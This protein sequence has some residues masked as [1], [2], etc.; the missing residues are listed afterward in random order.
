MKS[1]KSILCFCA[2]AVLLATTARASWFEFCEIEGEIDSVSVEKDGSYALIVN[3]KSA[4]RTSAEKDAIQSHTDCHEHI[5]KTVDA[6]FSAAEL[7]R[8]P[9]AG[10]EI[11]FSRSAIDAFS[12]D[13]KYAGTDINSRL[14]ALRKRER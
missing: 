10:D 6:Y 2:A 11:S 4:E 1:A 12:A 3:V 9:A 13:G 7:P 8:A 14:H 5:G